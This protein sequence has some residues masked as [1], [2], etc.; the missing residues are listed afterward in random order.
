[1]DRDH[2]ATLKQLLDRVAACHEDEDLCTT[3]AVR[4]SR[5]AR[6]LDAPAAERLAATSGGATLPM[7]ARALVDAADPVVIE[8]RAKADSTDVETAAAALRAAALLPL[9]SN[10][11]LRTAILDEGARS[12]III[13]E[14]TPDQVLSADFDASRAETV[15]A[16]FRGF[17][18]GNQDQLAALALLYGRP[19]AAERLTYAGL[20][21]LAD[22][23]ARPP[24]MLDSARVW[25]CYR[26]LHAA[27]VR[28]PSPARLLTDLVALVRFAL[29]TAT[30]L[31]TGDCGREPAVQ[32]MARARRTRRTGVHHGATG[33]AASVARPRRGKCGGGTGQ[34]ARGPAAFR[35]WWLACCPGRPGHRPP[36]SPAGRVVGHPDAAKI[37]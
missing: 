24:W 37:G 9:A 6:R 18:D 5:L 2:G 3:L 15:V 20:R 34:P 29:G 35:P 17:L 16:Q 21:E 23:M 32:S 8:T 13:D 31:E 30:V 10:P 28:D 25:L 36:A 12:E 26:R 27:Q 33:L 4:L 1:M 11:A 22:A 19:A 7:L 14:L